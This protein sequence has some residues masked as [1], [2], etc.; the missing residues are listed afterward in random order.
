MGAKKDINYYRHMALDVSL[1][2]FVRFEGHTPKA[3][4]C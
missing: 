4:G 1:L 3:D 2:C